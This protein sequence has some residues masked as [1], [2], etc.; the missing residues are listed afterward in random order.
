MPIFILFEAFALSAALSLDALIASFAYGSSGIRIPMSSVQVINLICS[1][2]LGFSLLAGSVI[3]Q[4]LPDGVTTALCFGIL[5]ILGL[6]K[7]FDGIMKAIIRKHTSLN[8]KI[9]FSMFSLRCVLTLYAD[10]EEAD[11]DRS[12]TI[13]PGEAASLAVALS[14]DGAAVGFGAAMGNAS[15]WAVFLCS[16]VTNMLAVLLGFRLGNQAARKLPFNLSWVSGAV[17]LIMAVSKLF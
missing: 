3:R 1:A 5:L 16:L 9:A 4:F 8:K 2:I 11:R 14:L 6:V 17:L 12:K 13:S 7:L 10:P 15:P